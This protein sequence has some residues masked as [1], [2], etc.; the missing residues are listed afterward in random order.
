VGE[1]VTWR[2]RIDAGRVVF[3]VVD[4]AGKV[5]ATRGDR[6]SALRV[7]VALRAVAEDAVDTIVV[8]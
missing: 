3:S 1:A 7:A 5:L 6:V 8:K 4:D 2:A